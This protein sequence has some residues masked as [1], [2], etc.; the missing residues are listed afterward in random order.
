MP[1]LSRVR[2]KPFRQTVT[3]GDGLAIDILAGLRAGAHTLLVLS[4]STSREVAESSEIKADY[5]F[6]DLADAMKALV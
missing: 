4:G 2:E 6:L 3:A 5:V 1:E